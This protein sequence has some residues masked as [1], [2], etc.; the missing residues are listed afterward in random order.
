MVSPS[1]TNTL[2]ARPLSTVNEREHNPGTNRQSPRWGLAWIGKGRLIVGTPWKVD[3]DLLVDW[4]YRETAFIAQIR[5]LDDYGVGT[6]TDK[7]IQDLLFSIADFRE[8]LERR[9][10]GHEPISYVLKR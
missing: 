8:S 5:G 4:E 6:S 10:G 3:F 1:T 2:L 9:G 7:A